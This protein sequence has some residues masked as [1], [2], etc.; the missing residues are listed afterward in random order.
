MTRRG[1]VYSPIYVPNKEFQLTDWV[2]PI[3]GKFVK[4]KTDSWFDMKRYDNPQKEPL[5]E[6]IVQAPIISPDSYNQQMKMIRLRRQN[7]EPVFI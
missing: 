5:Q 2:P 3:N 1:R 6:Y 7:K 4:L